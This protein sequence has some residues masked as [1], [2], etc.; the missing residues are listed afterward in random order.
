MLI[1]VLAAGS[2]AVYIILAT[3]LGFFFRDHWPLKFYDPASC[4]WGPPDRYIVAVLAL[5]WPASLAVM[6]VVWICGGLTWA[7]GRYADI[8]RKGR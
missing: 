1:G 2:L 7:F 5:I 8:F 4:S 3:A 6:T